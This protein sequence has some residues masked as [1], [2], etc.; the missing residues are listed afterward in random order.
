MDDLIENVHKEIGKQVHIKLLEIESH[1]AELKLSLPSHI[2]TST[3]RVLRNVGANFDTEI[4]IPR[5][6]EERL[7]LISS[8]SEKRNHLK[9]K[10]DDIKEQFEKQTKTHYSNIKK[11]HTKEFLNK[12]LG[13]LDDD[14]WLLLGLDM[15]KYREQL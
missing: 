13:E 2:K 12:K 11:K 5:N 7:R 8:T 4:Y 14:E 6:A 9:T 10:L 3:L 15:N 1:Y